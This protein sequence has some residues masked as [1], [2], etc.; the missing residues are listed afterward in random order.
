LAAF[1]GHLAVLRWLR[2]KGCSWDQ[3]TCTDAVMSGHFDVLQWAVANGCP[4]DRAACLESA[5]YSGDEDLMAW[6]AEQAAV[7]E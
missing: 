1:G 7:H 5:S 6:I 4:W 2:A 3:H